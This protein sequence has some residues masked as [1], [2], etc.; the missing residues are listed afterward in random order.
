M[1]HRLPFNTRDVRLRMQPGSGRLMALVVSDPVAL[2]DL[3]DAAMAL[4]PTPDPES[5]LAALS[6]R[7]GMVWTR[8]EE[9]RTIEWTAGFA[10]YGG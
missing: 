10:E 4:E 3:V 6:E 8:D 1:S 5:F 2:D 7:L 9:N